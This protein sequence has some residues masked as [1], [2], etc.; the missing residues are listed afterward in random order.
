MTAFCDVA[1]LLLAFFIMATKSKPP[2]AIS[3]VM[4]TSVS[5]KAVEEKDQ[6]MVTI[7]PDGKVFLSFSEEERRAEVLKEVAAA[8][9]IPVTQNDLQLAA[10]TEFFGAPLSQTISFLRLPKEEKKGSDMPGIPAKDSTNNELTLWMT[11]VQKV[12]LGEK[13]N[14]LVKGDNSAKYPVFKQ[15]IDAFKKNDL[16]KFAMVT[17]QENL[18]DDSELGKRLRA[19]GK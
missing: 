17:G 3:V 19:E 16:M 13:M 12:F 6:V 14:L 1:F 10:K 7:S 2:E 18:P 15:V 4:P 11:A 9:G 5:S 8:N